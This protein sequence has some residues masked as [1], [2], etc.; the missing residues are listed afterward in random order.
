MRIEESCGQSA[1]GMAGLKESHCLGCARGASGNCTNQYMSC[2]Y[3]ILPD[4]ET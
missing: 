3:S 1:L 4:E 2:Y